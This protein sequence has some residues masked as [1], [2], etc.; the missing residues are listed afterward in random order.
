MGYD[1]SVFDGTDFEQDEIGYGDV[2][3]SFGFHVILT[4][5]FGTWEGDIVTVLK[6]DDNRYGFLVIGFGS[7][8]GCDTIQGIRTVPTLKSFA[9]GLY[10]DIRWFDNM[11]GL[12]AWL[13]QTLV[14]DPGE[15]GSW[16]Y[17]DEE[18]RDWAR[19]FTDNIGKAT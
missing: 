18:I 7:C 16:Y 2:V 5:R 3:D 17:Y 8:S 11:T 6:D 15:P 1:A 9:M 10:R 19:G 13:V 14:N 4:E 12:A